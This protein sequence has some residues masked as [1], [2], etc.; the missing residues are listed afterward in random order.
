MSPMKRIAVGVLLA[1]LVIA[2][3]AALSVIGRAARIIDVAILFLAG[4]AAGV[5]LS[6]LLRRK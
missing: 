3:V 4:F 1:A 6:A 5:S 2:A